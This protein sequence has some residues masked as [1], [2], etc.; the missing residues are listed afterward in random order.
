MVYEILVQCTSQS[1]M[2]V[3]YWF[4]TEIINVISVWYY[5]FIK[6]FFLSIE[7]WQEEP[8]SS[9]PQNQLWCRRSSPIC[10]FVE[11]YTPTPTPTPQNLGLNFSIYLLINEFLLW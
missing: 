6:S 3:Q 9:T 4:F 1:S 11:T 8:S 5:V 7:R 10:R 2:H